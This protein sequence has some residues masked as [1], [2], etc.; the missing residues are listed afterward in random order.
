MIFI[1]GKFLAQ[2][3]TGVQRYAIELLQAFDALLADGAWTATG[4]VVL[5][6]PSTRIQPL[7]ALRHIQIRE[8][9]SGNLH[10]WEQVRLPWAARG[11]M[12]INLAGSTPLIK[13]GQVCTFHDTA[14]FDVPS[15]FSANFVR[16]YRLLFNAQGRLSRRVLTVSEFSKGRLVHHLG[17]DADK[18]AVVHCGADHMRRQPADPAVL[19]KLGVDA[20][21]YFLAV[22]SA[23]PNKNFSRLIEAFAGLEDPEARLVVV[24][25]SNATVFADSSD[26]AREDPRIVRAGRLTDDEIKALYSHARVYVFPSIYEGF[27][28]P[29]VEAMFCDCPVLAA[30]AASIPEIC[31][32]GAAFF[33]PY[34]VADIRASMRRALHDDAWLDDLRRA[35]GVRAE[36]FTWHNSALSLV[37]TLS[38]IGVMQARQARP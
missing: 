12:L 21:R 5:L 37:R 17:I 38:D 26:A 15:S 29:P 25:G 27:G 34:D 7:P 22:G 35:G 8:I 20:G 18:I 9:P 36:T 14:V 19:G 1:N 24:G 30:R 2:S 16:W 11:A 13:F 28:L 3:L 23:N 10:V 33:D 4:P 31:D 6:V 32:N